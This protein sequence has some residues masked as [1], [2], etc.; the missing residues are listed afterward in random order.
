MAAAGCRRVPA[1]SVA[2]FRDGRLAW[3]WARARPWGL[4]DAAVGGTV[5]TSTLFQAASI[6]KPVTTLG[7][8]LLSDDGRLALD[9]DIGQAVFGWHAPVPVT[10]RQVLSHT[11]QHACGAGGWHA[12]PELA[13]AARR[14][15]HPTWAAWPPCCKTVWPAA[16]CPC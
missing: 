7:A 10:P 5:D 11:G 6:S 1:V 14:P 3:A 2:V 12:Y 9:A 15:H 8:M 16:Q 4:R 13:A